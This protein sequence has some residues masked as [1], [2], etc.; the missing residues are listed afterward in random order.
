[1]P[2]KLNR[3]F[4]VTV[5]LGLVGLLANLPHFTIFTGA[6][7]FFGG[8]FYLAI[9]LM[10]GPMHGA[11]AALI[12]SLPAIVL[13]AHPETGCLM[14]AEALAVGWLA[15]KRVYPALA[16]LIYWAT[17]GTPVAALLYIVIFSYPS[18]YNWVMVVKHP[19]NGLLNVLLADISVTVRAATL[20][21]SVAIG[22]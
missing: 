6:R 17:V 4:A 20:S 19:A 10:Y 11:L 5:L 16:D 22:T 8:V 7:L 14:V 2:L 15:Q 12:S 3:S 18:P 13:W 1:M 9:A 21:P